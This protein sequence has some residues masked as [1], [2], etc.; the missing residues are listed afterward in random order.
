MRIVIDQI[1][2]DVSEGTSIMAAA[3]QL[4]IAI[5]SMCHYPGLKNNASCMVCMVKEENSGKFFPSC[6]MPAAEGMNITTQSPEVREVRK[7]ALELLLSD[8]IGDCEAPCRLSCPAFMD[9]PLMNRLIAQ[10]DFQQALD[11][12]RQEIALPFVLGYIC[13]APC[14][15]ACHRSSL[16][17]PVSI[18]LLK[19]ATAMFCESTSPPLLEERGPGGEVMTATKRGP[20]GE[21]MSATLRGSG[22][23]VMLTTQ[24]LPGGEVHTTPKKVAIIGTGPSGLTAAFYLLKAGH[25]CVL[26]DKND[27][28]GGELRYT[29]PEESLPKEV[30]D[31]EVG[32]IEQ[33]GAQFQMNF[34]IT[35]ELFETRILPE[36]DAVILAT[37]SKQRQPLHPFLPEGIDPDHFID[38]KH[39]TTAL[40]N[41]FACGNILQENKLAVRS[42]AQGKLAAMQVDRFLMAEPGAPFSTEKEPSLRKF[43]FHSLVGRLAEPELQEYLKES[44]PEKRGVPSKGWLAGFSQE[45][46]I[47]EAKRCLHCDC[48]KPDS[49]K[50]RILSEDYGAERRRFS[51]PHRK[52]LTKSMQHEFVVYE[53]EKCIRCGLCIE[54][55]RKEESA[56]GMAFIGRGFD[57]QVNV[58]FNESL[59]EALKVTAVECVKT[60]PTGALAFKLAE[61][62]VNNE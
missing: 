25:D 40:S 41:V 39:F 19:R 42:A 12:V 34:L 31:Q 29:I 47:Q 61:E 22:G 14:E 46:A 20:G 53:P 26:F 36:F 24:R 32:Y 18:C 37:G 35:K 44:I 23:E 5:P 28:A 50:L 3:E 49:C 11:V 48:R 6:A 7:Q 30:L 21:V 13:P 8:H 45:E 56:L 58:P 1:P 54:V 33:M 16:D 52:L 15:K 27:K 38:H 10:G 62:R 60:C 9:I 43:R 57:I 59:K 2:V 51:G 55:S 4:G 17:A